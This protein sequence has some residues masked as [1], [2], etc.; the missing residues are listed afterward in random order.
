MTLADLGWLQSMHS[1]RYVAVFMSDVA[2]VNNVAS[3]AMTSVAQNGL[4]VVA[5]VGAMFYLDWQLSLF[6]VAVLPVGIV[7]TRAQR[8]S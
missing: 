1:G 4:Q 6:V 8:R 2:A 5:L 3:Q 7:L